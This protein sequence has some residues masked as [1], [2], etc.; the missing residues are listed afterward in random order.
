[1]GAVRSSSLTLRVP[2]SFTTRKE[3]NVT[4]MMQDYPR[5]SIMRELLQNVF[6]CDYDSS[7]IKVMIEFLDEGQVKLSDNET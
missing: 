7:D 4:G 2:S 3:I 5:E 1:M 6:G